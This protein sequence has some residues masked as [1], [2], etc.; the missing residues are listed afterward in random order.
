MLNLIITK[1]FKKDFNK[2]KKKLSFSD[3]KVLFEVIEKLQEKIPLEPKYKDHQLSGKHNDC[4]DCHIKP[5]LV[6]I[7]YVKDNDLILERLN[8]HSE[9]FD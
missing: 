2:F 8:S 1:N 3:L 4:R 5:D 9:L 6:L 7:Y